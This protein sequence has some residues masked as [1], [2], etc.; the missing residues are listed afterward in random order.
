MFSRRA[1]GDDELAV[2]R[3]AAAIERRR[4]NGA[5]LVDLTVSNPTEV[6][7]AYPTGELAAALAAGAGEAYRPD[8]RGLLSARRAVA[9]GFAAR[10]ADVAPE[11]LFLTASTSEAYG[12]LF[13]LLCEP[14]DEV[15]VPRPSYPLFEQLARLE[16]VVA[17]SYRLGPSPDFALDPDRIEVELNARTRAVVVVSPNNPTGQVASAA[18]LAELGSLCAARGVALISDEVFAD[19]HGDGPPPAS[20]LSAAAGPLRFALG[21]LSKSCGLPHFKLG[22]VAAAGPA[23]KLAPALARLEHIADSYLS[24]STPVMAA[25]PRLLEIG[26]GLRDAIAARV[27]DNRARAALVLAGAR[28]V[29]LL[30]AAGGWTACL[31]LDPNMDEEEL[32]LELAERHGVLVHPG[33]FF[34]FDRGSHAVVSLLVPGAE[35]EQGLAA[36]VRLTESGQAPAPAQDPEPGPPRRRSPA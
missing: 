11:H 18:A 29:R 17:R 22:W 12:F 35:L 8:P 1:P 36:L 21:G 25:L 3:L 4:A 16:A 2:N 31:E 5:E 30:P 7:L 9:A 33:Y 13:K 28:R 32:A 14:G 26:A 24:V 34:D 10:G 20:A 23:D 19:Y 6:G 27:A 15:L